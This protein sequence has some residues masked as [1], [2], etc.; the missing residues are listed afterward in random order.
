MFRKV[1]GFR[2][3]YGL[4]AKYWSRLEKILK[5]T[6]SDFGYGEFILPVLEKAEVFAKGIG[7]TTD[8]VEK[9]MFAFTDRDDSKV[10]LRPE[11][12]ASLVRSYIEN[13][14]YNPPEVKKYFYIGPMFR[15]ERPQKGRFRQFYQA[16]IE[17][18]GS[19]SPVIDA[20]VIAL[21][22]TVADRIGIADD[23]VMEINSIGCPEC[24]PGY[25]E[26]LVEYLGSHRDDLCEDCINRL[27]RNP[28]RILDC[29]SKQCKEITAQAP[30]MLDSLCVNCEMHFDKV[31]K[32]LDIYQIPYRTNAMMVR[33]LD[34]YVQTAFEL[35]TESLGSQNAVGAGGRYDGLVSLMG[36]PETAGIGFALGI[37]RMVALS[38]MK[39]DLAEDGP[40]VYII[41]FEGESDKQA[42][43][44][45]HGLRLAGVKCEMDYEFRAMKK[46]FKKAD[47]S[48]AS[49]TVILGSEE[50][51]SGKYAVKN[52]VSGE[53][54][55]IPAGDVVEYIKNKTV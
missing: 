20:D 31:K 1:K 47:S 30:V 54:E 10:A 14:L 27:D 4:E 29:K 52:L 51:Q 38:M 21:L 8:I 24:R 5:D 45:M 49:F 17:V 44:L 32:Y 22:Y 41:C 19:D 25:N 12:T 23:C 28:M 42:A 53:Q 26:K 2:D 50:I 9:E 40:D 46:Q 48:G 13:K 43:E 3:I 16:G 37:D 39:D 6:F 7:G 36:G 35:V 18:L 11:G 33:G 34:Y 15:R 55:S